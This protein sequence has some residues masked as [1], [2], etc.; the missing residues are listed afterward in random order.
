MVFRVAVLSLIIVCP[1]SCTRHW[2]R[3]KVVPEDQ[4]L[5]SRQRYKLADNQLAR[6]SGVL[7][8]TNDRTVARLIKFL[9]IRGYRR[10][11]AGQDQAFASS[12]FVDANSVTVVPR[13][14][15]EYTFNFTKSDKTC[16]ESAYKWN[17]PCNRDV[18][19]NFVRFQRVFH[20]KLRLSRNSVA[21]VKRMFR[22]TAPFLSWCYPDK[23][24]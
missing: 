23:S 4:C 9:I 2:K 22:D 20:A 15:K 19:M 11:G 18:G 1:N 3:E 7:E 13:V 21:R 8:Q 6:T 12:L 17:L 5:L 16:L 14:Q 24:M 10:R